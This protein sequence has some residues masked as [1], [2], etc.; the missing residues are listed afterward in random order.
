MFES[1]NGL[2]VTAV[3]V[4]LNTHTGVLTYANAGHNLPLLRRASSGDVEALPKGGTAL[5]VYSVSRLK[6]YSIQVEPGDWSVFYTD[7]VTESFS[8]AGETFGEARLKKTIQAAPGANSASFLE[9]IRNQLIEFR[10]GSPPSDDLTLV[11]LHHH[12]AGTPP[13]PQPSSS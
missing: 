13:M 5:G 7:G 3:F 9:H 2:F 6:D 1:Q 12:G 4:I 10:E 11:V 8:P